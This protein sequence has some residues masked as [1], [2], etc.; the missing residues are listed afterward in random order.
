MSFVILGFMMLSAYAFAFEVGGTA[1]VY[2]TDNYFW[3]ITTLEVKDPH[4]QYDFSLSASIGKLEASLTQWMSYD[5]DPT[6]IAQEDLGTKNIDEVD[7]ILNFGYPVGNLSI[8]AGAIYYDVTNAPETTEVYGSLGYEAEIGKLLSL[9]PGL[10]FYY[11][12]Q[13]IKKAYLEASLSL[14]TPLFSYVSL[15]SILGYDFGQ[16]ALEGENGVSV[17]ES[18]PTALQLGISADYEI[19]KGVTIS[20]SFTYVLGLHD[21]IDNSKFAVLKFGFDF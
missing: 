5:I 16:F 2:V 4:I 1:N 10:K 20:P 21:G 15:N 18:K 3:R 6:A 17:A 7:Y 14:G 9:S 19:T 13:E 12:V 11:D 8:N